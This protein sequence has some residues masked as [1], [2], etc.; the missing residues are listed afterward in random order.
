MKRRFFRILALLLALILLSACGGESGEE[1]G[2]GEG[3]TCTSGDLTAPTI[4][5]PYSMEVVG[6]ASPVITWGY[7]PEPGAD[8]SCLPDGFHI[9]LS[10]A[11]QYEVVL[12][13]ADLAGSVFSWTAPPLEAGGVYRVTVQA[14]LAG[15]SGPSSARRFLTGPICSPGMLAAPVLISP[16]NGATLTEAADLMWDNPIGCL[17]DGY[18]VALSTESAF[19]APVTDESYYIPLQRIIM[20]PEF[21]EPCTTYYWHVAALQGD[22]DAPTAQSDFSDTWSFYYNPSGSCAPAGM[23]GA[24]V[25]KVWHDLC[26]LPETG[27]LPDPLPVGCVA[28][29]G[30][31]TA[32]GILTIGEP[33]I[34]GVVVRMAS[35]PCP[36][37]GTQAVITDEYGNYFFLADAGTYCLSV[38]SLDTNN[39]DILIP[40]DWTSPA[41]AAG[42]QV[43]YRQ[44]TMTADGMVT[45]VNFGWDYQ[46]LPEWGALGSISGMVWE[47]QCAYDGIGSVPD[48]LPAGC[49]SWED[50]T[51]LGNGV[52]DSG[53]SP[54]PGLT[55]DLGLG[56]CPSAGLL[57]TVTDAEGRYR[58]E[59][60]PPGRYCVRINAE[61][62]GNAAI[63][64]PGRWS[65]VPGG[66]MGMTFQPVAME[67]TADAAE[68][69]FA[70]DRTFPLSLGRIPWFRVR[71]PAS[72]RVGPGNDYPV[73]A[74]L[75]PDWLLP[76]I[77]R[78]P[79]GNWLEVLLPA[80]PFELREDQVGPL[81]EWLGLQ[82]LQN[83]PFQLDGPGGMD[84]GA[85]PADPLGLRSISLTGNMRRCWVYFELGDLLGIGRFSLP[86]LPSPPL[87]LPEPTPTPTEAPVFSCGVYAN[88]KLC[89]ADPRCYWHANLQKCLN[90]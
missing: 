37:P 53:E 73:H 43:A 85:L 50:G 29:G 2:G 42:D 74:Y 82:K 20:A 38:D 54:I 61:D 23:R 33:G 60:L 27:P 84:G 13:E 47:D 11:P 24:V 89:T 10:A 35:G 77:G 48:P 75:D 57:T 88:E 45:D 90:R 17:V 71:L 32:D 68:R 40:G 39:D 15:A 41:D 44:V 49:T 80:D 19:V 6:S 79:K 86:V 56:D 5:T 34:P 87:I 67:G 26:A 36:A 7:A 14:R 58:F 51:V 76:V 55:V 8:A 16:P 1:K 12:Y 64:L 3:G 62:E 59:H 46:F 22:W 70:W 81:L 30:S 18:R 63:L 52:L 83:G 9:T 65:L 31:A 21:L 4:L 66:H 72:C 69:N 78:N 28:S 25:G